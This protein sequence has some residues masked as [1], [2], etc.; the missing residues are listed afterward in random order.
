MASKFVPAVDLLRSLG[1]MEPEEID[2]YAIAQSTGATVVE[3]QVTGCEARIVGYGEKALIVVNSG[4]IWSRRRFSAAHELGHWMRDAK[5]ISLGCNPEAVIGSENANVE[6]RANGYASDVL[7]PKFMFEPRAKGRPAT[8]ETA[9][10]LADV[11][12]TSLTATSLRLVDYGSFPAMVV[13]SDSQRVRW[14]RRSVEVPR[15]LWPETAG[16]LTFAD[17]LL[18]GAPGGARTSGDV[19]SDQWFPS[20][21]PHT[22]HEDSR[23]I[24]SE[25][26][27]TLLWWNDEGSLVEIQEKQE[28]WEYRRADGYDDD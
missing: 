21:S 28:Q 10:D 22:I 9:S 14:F 16:R 4:S 6:T 20:A 8:L 7:M 27:L 11:F 25:L 12:Q 17:E 23:R 1:I 2:I 24:N 26:V 18:R 13:C 5:R 15:S 3:K 19:Y